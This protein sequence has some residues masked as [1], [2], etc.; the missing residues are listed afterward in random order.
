MQDNYTPHHHHGGDHFDLPRWPTARTWMLITLAVLALAV[1]WLAL[2]AD[3]TQRTPPRSA[4]PPSTA[5]VTGVT[6]HQV[7]L[8]DGRSMTCLFFPAPSRAISCDWTNA[9]T[10]P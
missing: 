4:P 8:T 5:T 7:S 1:F 3:P 2:T 10:A 9:R 6:E